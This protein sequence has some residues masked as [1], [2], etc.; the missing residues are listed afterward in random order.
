MSTPLRWTCPSSY[1]SLQAL[2]EEAG[3]HSYEYRAL[4][5]DTDPTSSVVS[6][7][8]ADESTSQAFFRADLDQVSPPVRTFFAEAVHVMAASVERDYLNVM[9]QRNV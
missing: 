7:H 1:A 2:A 6:L 8:W 4:V 3:I 5:D 9:Q